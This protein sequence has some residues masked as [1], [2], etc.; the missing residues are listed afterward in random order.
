[1]ENFYEMPRKEINS[2]RDEFNK[3]EY[4]KRINNS[5]KPAG[6]IF[7]LVAFIFGVV[8][9]AVTEENISSTIMY[10]LLWF[11]LIVDVISLFVYLK[12][13]KKYSK[14]FLRWLKIKHNIES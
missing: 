10:D 14:S 5:R 1:M 8:F 11:L 13:D 7:I 2:L 4:T 3:L 6:Y 12:N 9:S